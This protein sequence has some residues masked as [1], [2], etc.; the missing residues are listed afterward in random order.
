MEAGS[1]LL[2][3]G[4]VALLVTALGL[5]ACQSGDEAEPAAAPASSSPAAPTTSLGELSA[6][7]QEE[8]NTVVDGGIYPGIVLLVRAGDESKVLTRGVADQKQEEPLTADHRFWIGS[9]TKPIVAG[10][11]LQ[12]VED[13]RLGLNDPVSDWLPGLLKDGDEITVEHLLTHTSGLSEVEAAP[14]E[15]KALVGPPMPAAL[16]RVAEAQGPDFAPGQKA[17]YSNTGFTVLGLVVEEVT[18]EP[19]EETVEAMVFVPLRMSSSSLDWREADTPPLAH[20]YAD[21]EDVTDATVLGWAW[22]AGGAVATAGD[23]SRFFQGLLGGAVVGP[24]L[25]GE[26][27]AAQVGD[28]G[29]GAAHYG[30]GLA[31]LD[32]RCGIAY[33]HSGRIEGYLTEAWTLETLD[34]EVVILVNRF[35]ESTS[36]ITIESMVEQALCD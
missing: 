16:V 12:L 35:D 33:G 1:S 36:G 15:I 23:V 5:S 7:I 6:S 27:T 9:V 3:R 21:D 17:A 31:Q 20:G 14:G 30:F 25:L 2:R 11:V 19:L 8:M 22:A 29:I 10:V 24:D 32:T 13:G 26:M 34:R 18:G 28:V 4:V